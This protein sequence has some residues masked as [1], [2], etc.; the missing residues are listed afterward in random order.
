MGRVHIVTGSQYGDEGKAKMTDAIANL[1]KDI[2]DVIRTSGGANAGHTVVVNGKKFVYNILPSAALISRINLHLGSGMFIDIEQLA[3]EIKNA[4]SNG[5]SLTYR[6]NLSTKASVVLPIFKVIDE[7]LDIALGIGT[8]KR[9]IGIAAAMKAYRSGIRVQDLFSDTT[10]VVKRLVATLNSF[11]IID[12]IENVI[13]SEIH[14]TRSLLDELT[15][16]CKVLLDYNHEKTIHDIIYHNDDRE[17]LIEGAQG[18]MI[19]TTFGNYPYVTSSSTTVAGLF[20]QLGVLPYDMIGENIG[21]FKPYLTRVGNGD[22]PT[23]YDGESTIANDL[24]SMGNEFGAT[25]GRQRRVGYLNMDELIRAV[26]ING[27]NVL[28]M[29]KADILGEIGVFTYLYNG[30][31]VNIPVTKENVFEVIA[32]EVENVIAVRVKYISTGPD[33]DQL[34]LN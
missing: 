7:K 31:V 17:L 30:E 25:T 27:Y 20:A 24:T 14:N 29:C 3:N 11:D 19:D 32:N 8:T 28:A 33:R 15:D 26:E 18:V 6:V 22:F 1:N 2:T 12:D 23:E 4:E 10:D 21:V 16:N 9:G 34:I 13:Q 5:V